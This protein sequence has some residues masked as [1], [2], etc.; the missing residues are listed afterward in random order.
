M[1]AE[2]GI[3]IRFTTG[4][5]GAGVVNGMELAREMI[6]DAYRLLAPYAGLCPA[7]ADDLF[8]C[9]AN[10]AIEN[11]HVR[12]RETGVFPTLVLTVGATADA[13]RKRF[14]AHLEA[15]RPTVRDVLAKQR[16]THEPHQAQAPQTD[17]CDERLL[18]AD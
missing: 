12:H 7:C 10:E 16:R 6:A 13:R 3:H 5:D 15:Q 14:D 9:I 8:I 18:E 2:S 11:L 17:E 4:P 1:A